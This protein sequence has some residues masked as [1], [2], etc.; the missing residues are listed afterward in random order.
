MLKRLILA[1]AVAGLLSPA[2]GAGTIPYSLSQQLDQYG[3]PLSGCKLYV[4]KAGTTSTPQNAFQDS[5]LTL[6]LPNPI[7]C[8]SAGRL[9]QFFLADGSIKVRLTSS[10]GVNQAVADNILVIGPS[11]GAGTGAGTIDAT[12]ILATGDVKSRYGTGI[13]A[14]FVRLN[15]RTIGSAT[16]GATER[17]NA[18]SQALF[19]YL[20]ATDTSLIVSAGRGA[21]A[22]ADWVANKTLTLPDGRGR[23]LAGLDD[24]G[25]VSSGRLTS[26]Y[27]GVSPTVLGAVGGSQTQQI[28]QAQLPAVAP[29]FTGNT[30]GITVNSA[31]TN[32]TQGLFAVNSF[33][34]GGTSITYFQANPV[35]SQVTSTGSFTP[36]GSIS[37]LGSGSPLATLPPSLLITNYMKL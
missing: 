20:W 31:P 25:S 11:G 16:S 8:D 28:L 17:A 10:A 12:T 4:I 15:G 7:I 36:S 21:S 30:A 5:A 3:K 19:E 18:D 35:S 2:Y 14:G 6:P 34:G 22:N 9:P 13:L 27:Y 1:L 24:M 23:V 32:I 26:T 29:T 33:S 37:P